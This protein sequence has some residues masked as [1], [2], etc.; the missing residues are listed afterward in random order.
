MFVSL[1]CFDLKDFSKFYLKMRLNTFPY[2]FKMYDFFFSI[3]LA[4]L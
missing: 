4:S 2:Y 1:V 3:K